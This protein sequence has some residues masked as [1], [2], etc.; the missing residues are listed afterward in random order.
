MPSVP[1]L[2]AFEPERRPDVAHEM[3]GRALA[4]GAGDGGDGRGLQAG[5]RRRH[6]RDAAA[7]IGVAHDDDAVIE[8]R[9]DRIG[10]GE[11]GRGA[12]L[13]GVG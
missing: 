4:V 7:R 12:A 3:D 5:E 11:D 9:Q 10:R 2:A 1:T 8:R 13:H 6:Q